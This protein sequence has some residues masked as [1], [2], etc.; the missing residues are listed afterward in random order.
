MSTE[1][2]GATPRPN[3]VCYLAL[4]QCYSDSPV[5]L[6]S[7]KYGLLSDAE[8]GKRLVEKCIQFGHWSVV[9]QAY[10]SFN[11]WGYP[12]DVLVQ[13][14][15]HRHMSFSAQSQ[16]Y[17]FKRIHEMGNQYLLH[18][19][20]PYDELQK[21]FYF[22]EP[23]K[24][25]LDRE[26]NKYIYRQSQFEEDVLRTFELV[27]KFSER[28]LD[29]QAPEHARQLLPQNIRQHFVLGC[30]A[31]ALLHFCDLRLP[32]DAQGEIRHMAHSLFTEFEALMPEVAQWYRLNRYQ[33][34]KLS[35]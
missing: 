27:V 29:G 5:F 25:Y 33:K 28:I 3:L 2:I 1:L 24:H 4:H 21:L 8:L 22:R 9:E 6:E 30:N 16:R 15:T 31:R 23:E 20:T 17:T 14:R 19:L 10:F 12:H 18:G 13:A 32:K 26:A 7:E 11:V 34:S 35:P